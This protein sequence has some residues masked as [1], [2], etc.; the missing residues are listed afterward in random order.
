MTTQRTL[1]ELAEA[2]AAEIAEKGA[3]QCLRCGMLLVAP[4]AL[5]R[6]CHWQAHQMEISEDMPGSRVYYA[7]CGDLVKI[8]RSTGVSLRMAQL[9]IRRA[10][11]TEPGGSWWEARR[12]QQFAHLRVHGEWFRLDERLRAHI[13]RMRT[14]QDGASLYRV[15]SSVGEIGR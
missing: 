11:A 5:T 14:M 8:G 6:E 3:L 9:N 7:R 10:M 13:A 2:V 12:H 15:I 4:S 1:I